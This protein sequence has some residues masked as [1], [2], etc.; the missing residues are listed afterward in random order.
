MLCFVLFLTKYS[1]GNKVFLGI[2]LENIFSHAE[3]HNTKP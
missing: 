1:L 2:V 3:S